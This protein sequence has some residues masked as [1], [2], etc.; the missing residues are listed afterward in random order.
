MSIHEERDIAMEAAIHL[1][2]ELQAQK[3]RCSEQTREI[4]RLRKRIEAQ[5]KENE[6]LTMILSRS[7]DTPAQPSFPESTVLRIHVSGNG[8]TEIP[9]CKGDSVEAIMKQL[10][11]R[12]WWWK[13]SHAAG[14]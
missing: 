10:A 14:L 13:L 6:R 2:R 8:Y 3:S 12:C 4:D 7:S 1:R 11:L 5:D 9:V